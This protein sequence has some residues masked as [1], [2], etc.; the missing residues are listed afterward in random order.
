MISGKITDENGKPISKA[1]VRLE[2]NEEEI[3]EVQTDDS[4]KYWIVISDKVSGLYDLSATSG[5]KGN[6]QFGIRLHDGMTPCHGES[7]TVDLTLKE[8]IS[9]E[10]QLLMLD[11]STPHVAVSVQAIRD[12]KIIDGT[13]SDES[14]KYKLVNLKQGRYQV[15]CQIPGD[16]VCRELTIDNNQSEK[17]IDF[18]FPAFKKGTWRNYNF[19]DGLPGNFVV[20]IHQSPDGMLWF[21]TDSG[22]SRYDGKEFVNFTTKDGLAG[23]WVRS[24]H[25]SSDDVFWFGVC[26]FWTS[27]DG[28]VSRYD[29]NEFVNFTTKDGLTSNKVY[30]I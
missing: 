18:S 6:W 7:Q 15:R 16:D 1:S 21:G 20:A 25:Q 10:G 23:N 29:G 30:A 8:A 17:E 27:S 14:E 4:G 28:G 2:Q 26:D 11:D 19:L 13:L 24:I 22:V 5:E 12:G 3:S 9:I